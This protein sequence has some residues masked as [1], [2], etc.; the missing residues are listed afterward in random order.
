MK[1]HSGTLLDKKDGVDVIDCRECGFAHVMPLPTAREVQRFYEKDFY[2]TEMPDYFKHAEEDMEWWMTTYDH[3]YDLLEA[4]TAGRRLLDIGSGPGYFLDAGIKRG[5]ETIGFEPSAAAARYAEGRGLSIVNSMFS[6]EKAT[7]YGPFDAVVINLVFEHVPDPIH[8]IE[9]VK[10]ILAP[11]GLLCIITPNDYNPLQKLLV[12]RHGFNPWWVVPKHHLNYFTV[13]SLATLL[14]SRGLAPVEAETS[15]PMEFF[16]LSGRNY[17]TDR[18]VGRACHKE[19][20]A[21]EKALFAGDKALLCDLY[22]AWAKEGIGRE[23]VIVARK[24]D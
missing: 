5:W 18:E 24:G 17:V 22:R 21:M 6:S 2:D 14:E 23:A 4:H 12:K 3:Y 20:M 10:R 15:Y 16:L 11:G 8:L 19:R 13:D 7:A 9:D 1:E